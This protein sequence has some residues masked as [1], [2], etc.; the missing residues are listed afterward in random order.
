MLSACGDK[1][2]SITFN[3]INPAT[4]DKTVVTN[5]SYDNFLVLESINNYNNDAILNADSL[6]GESS[7]YRNDVILSD[8]KSGA[9]DSNLWVKNGE[10][11]ILQTGGLGQPPSVHKIYDNSSSKFI[12]VKSKVGKFGL[13]SEPR[14]DMWLYN[15]KSW[16][17][18]TGGVNQP[19]SVEEVYGT[20]SLNSIVIKE[21]VNNNVVGYHGELWIYDGKSWSKQTGGNNQPPSV[22]YIANGP[23]S[24]SLIILDDTF[25]HDVWI[26]YGK[27][28]KKLTGGFNQPSRVVGIYGKNPNPVFLVVADS[29]SR[30]WVYNGKSWNKYFIWNKSNG[31]VE[32][33]Y[34]NV[35]P[36][37]FIVK[38]RS[39]MLW[40]Y[41]GKFWTKLTG[42]P[43]QPK[44]VD[45]VEGYPS[46]KSIVLKDK[47][48]ILWLYNG[49]SW[50]WQSGGAGQPPSVN[51]IFGSPTVNSIVL[52]DNLRQNLWNYN[53]KSWSQLTGL[54]NQPKSVNIMFIVNQRKL[55]N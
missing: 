22:E 37:M 36:N 54:P 3:A 4:N 12:L 49:K 28:W 46:S 7:I 27:R 19:Q 5:I 13:F 42:G 41:N 48:S 30:L 47:D 26:F 2:S 29:D 9:D 8:N 39:S 35:T 18:Q 32:F 33:V 23:T 53:G 21:K 6:N 15:G 52:Q 31:Y 55:Q 40:I 44:N 24:S 45:R 10:S 25:N 14:E 51:K 11:W 34:G 43:N 50:S 16:T 17:K 1:L 20:P 38:D